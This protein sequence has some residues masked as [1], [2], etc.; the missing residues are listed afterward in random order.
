MMKKV[1]LFAA[2]IALLVAATSVKAQDVKGTNYLNAGIGIGTFALKGSGGLPVTA[3][4]EHGF[5]NYVS[6]GIFGGMIKREDLGVYKFTYVI[7][8]LRGSYHFNELLDIDDKKLDLYGGASLYYRGYKLKYTG[9]TQ[10]DVILTYKESD[11]TAGLGFHAG[12][13]YLIGTNVG[14]YAELGVGILTLQTG[15]AVKFS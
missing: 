12:A 10:G 8:G 14:V 3:S 7:T 13:R 5:S 15:V 4:F 2:M 11:G 9:E 1:K 6:A